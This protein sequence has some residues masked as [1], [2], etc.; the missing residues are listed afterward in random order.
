MHVAVGTRCS[1][2]PVQT[3]RNDHGDLGDR[4]DISWHRDNELVI[5]SSIINNNRRHVRGATS[6]LPVRRRLRSL[7]HSQYEP[8]VINIIFAIIILIASCTEARAVE[9]VLDLFAPNSVFLF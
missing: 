3:G 6:L 2:R 1:Q 9:T 4:R 5:K 7:I 8:N